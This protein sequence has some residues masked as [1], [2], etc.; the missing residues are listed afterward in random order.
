MAYGLK[1]N[2]PKHQPCLKCGK[3][4]KRVSQSETTAT[5]YCPKC[6]IESTYSL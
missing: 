6:K 3:R 5:Y 2:S 1:K 4:V